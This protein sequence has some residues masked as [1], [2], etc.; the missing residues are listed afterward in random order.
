MQCNAFATPLERPNIFEMT[1]KCFYL[2]FRLWSQYIKY[3]K[4]YYRFLAT[5]YNS[6]LT[7][8]YL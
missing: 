8:N 1:S 3:L 5:I 4:Q 7:L 2:G 6:V